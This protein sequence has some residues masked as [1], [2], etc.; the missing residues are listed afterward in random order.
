MALFARCSLVRGGM[1]SKRFKCR[2]LP[3]SF[4]GFDC[5]VLATSQ[6]SSLHDVRHA[7]HTFG[8]PSNHQQQRY[9]SSSPIPAFSSTTRIDSST[10]APGPMLQRLWKESVKTGR[11]YWKGCLKV[12]DEAK[13]ASKLKKLGQERSLTRN[14]QRLIWRSDRD[15]G[16]TV[17]ALIYFC[18]PGAFY[19]LPLVLKFASHLLPRPFLLPAQKATSITSR[20]TFRTKHSTQQNLR[21][22]T[23]IV[24]GSALTSPDVTTL[25]MR[26]GCLYSERLDE[27]RTQLIRKVVHDPAHLT[28]L[29]L[30]WISIFLSTS[31]MQVGS[32]DK[33]DMLTFCNFLGVP[34]SVFS[35]ETSLAKGLK[36]HCNRLVIDDA[37][38]SV[39]GGLASLNSKQLLKACE[40]RGL[41]S[42]V[43]NNDDTPDERLKQRLEA[44]F[45]C[46][47]FAYDTLYTDVKEGDE[48]LLLTHS[49]S[50]D[51]DC[52]ILP[53]LSPYRYYAPPPSPLARILLPQFLDVS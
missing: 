2:T 17:P 10:P 32:F 42:K 22:H 8:V 39:D 46:T 49:Y 52:F 41:I 37:Y 47:Q 15:V 9:L 40:E 50:D 43:P 44:Y 28:P 5:S 34:A 12:V 20:H 7:Q 23:A 51:D 16:V 35:S 1:R 29:D 25:S 53:P 38:L 6:S 48:P 27:K 30:R 11:F 24:L 45:E 14:E 21:H 26:V 19:S 31:S 36:A 18:L 4:R 13:R 3:S 33:K